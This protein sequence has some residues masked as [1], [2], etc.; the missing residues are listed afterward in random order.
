VLGHCHHLL[1]PRIIEAQHDD[2][3]LVDNRR[4]VAVDHVDATRRA[5]GVQQP[6]HDAR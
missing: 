3:S 4:S 2:A 1:K 5:P 6:P